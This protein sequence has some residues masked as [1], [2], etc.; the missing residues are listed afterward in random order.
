ML[1][2]LVDCGSISA[3]SVLGLLLAIT[4]VGVLEMK[5]QAQEGTAPPVVIQGTA[6]TTSGKPLA[7]TT[8]YLVDL[9]G[10]QTLS[11]YPA[12]FQ[13]K[14]IVVTDAQGRF[15]WTIPKEV[16]WNFPA[17]AS[18]DSSAPTC[19]ALPPGHGE[20]AAVFL[21]SNWRGA[22]ADIGR[23][24]L[25][26]D[27]TRRCETHWLE[28]GNHPRISVVAPDTGLVTLTV[29][30]T[31]GR[32]LANQRVQIVAPGTFTSY[33]GAVVYTVRTN[34]AGQ[35]SLARYT[36]LLRLLVSVPGTGFGST[37][38]F[39]VLSGKEAAPAL[40]P[41]APFAC[42][43][44]SVIPALVK[45]GAFVHLDDYG[46]ND[47]E[48]YQPQAAVDAR[49]HFMLAG[50]LPGQHRL[51]LA[52]GQ[53]AAA[54]EVTVH[55]GETVT[56]L[57]LTKLATPQGGLPSFLTNPV[58]GTKPTMCGRVVTTAGQPVEAA[59]V[60]A[61][62]SYNG[63]MR[64]Y[65]DVLTARTGADGSYAIANVPT[66]QGQTG[67]TLVAVKAGFPLGMG[68]ASVDVSKPLSLTATDLVLPEG[69][70][71]LTVRVLQN[72]KP[73]SGASVN[74]TPQVGSN[75][76]S[77]FRMNAGSGPAQ[78]R[79]TA[80]LNPSGT[81]DT[82][83][84][85]RF[86]DLAPG[87][88]DAAANLG[89]AASFFG[90]PPPG[91]SGTAR[92]IVV[93][94]G[95]P[96]RFTLGV[97]AAPG[98]VAFR[99]LAPGGQPPPEPSVALQLGQASEP[100]GG[101]GSGLTLDKEGNG[102]TSVWAP[103]LW[104][105]TTR[106]R[107]TPLATLPANTEP[108][109]QGSALVAVSPALAPAG[110]IQIRTV[111]HGPGRIRVRLEDRTGRR[112]AGTVT[113]GD[114]FDSAKYALSVGASGEAVFP[115]LPSGSYLL[116]AS[117]A[118]TIAPP[119]LG[120][121]GAAFPA[122]AALAGIAL[123]VPQ[124][125]VVTS[126]TETEVTFRPQ[127][128]GYIRGKL[129]VS[130]SPA[131]YAVYPGGYQEM[132]SAVHYEPKT[133]EFVVGPFPP[134]KNYLWVERLTPAN[135][136]LA[137][138]GTF[139]EDVPAG[140]VLT[141]TLTPQPPSVPLRDRP[142]TGR[143]FLPDGITPAWGARAAL[144]IPDSDQPVKMARTDALGQLNIFDYWNLSYWDGGGRPLTPMPGSPTEPVLVAWLPGSNGA[145]IIPS[146]GED[147][148]LVLPPPLSVSGRVTVGGQP[149]L[150]TPSSFRVKAAYQGRG[151]LNPL[152][153]VS[154]AVQ[155]DG[156]FTLSGLTLGTYQVQAARDDLWLSKTQV[157]TVTEGSQPP[158]T[159][160][161]APP[162]A[163]MLLHLATVSGNALPDQTVSLDRPTGP[164]TDLL[165]PVTA[166][167]D[168]HGDLRLDGLEAGPH[169]VDGTAA[170]TV[171][172]QPL[173]SP[174]TTAEF[175][176]ILNG[177]GTGKKSNR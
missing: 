62:C 140:R 77:F 103:G 39:Q 33:E 137:T 152:L 125:A 93:T 149:V 30:G 91:V 129:A 124:T 161:I 155:A 86:R 133:G 158:L 121:T 60:Y 22:N 174:R 25:W 46:V 151:K 55:A 64:G 81:T 17:N 50:V 120:H 3:R 68:S 171:P 28:T 56:G 29:H 83:G 26:E 170:F 169:T 71:A 173:M 135:E 102:H 145:V 115:D 162:G 128:L 54:A 65:Q 113:I 41:L 37:G 107:D 130:D 9:P 61:I 80:C 92:G 127:P 45:P 97:C 13:Q 82:S 84:E 109:Y 168:S 1:N 69:H 108:F 2:N 167:S 154:A 144:M 142:L 147:A 126:D 99:V 110:P 119:S 4:C 138:G 44:G 95:M 32:I 16:A 141:V 172:A 59:D 175:T 116:K 23:R 58:P 143:V 148:K 104:K 66:G 112:A 18:K 15:A 12:G 57:V 47:H 11:Q 153:S 134:G 98:D 150:G 88:W 10:S 163:V 35:F 49:G 131:H 85:V 38:T 27:A 157:L 132:P 21:A 146:T 63:G 52:G 6:T 78:G 14:I 122:D 111:H 19:Y 79:V 160:D 114:S 101:G 67:I 53:G 8:L 40:P 70:T 7:G 165:W 5:G 74:L 123:L 51:V 42:L 89:G 72:G 94:N 139:P 36:G 105:L 96:S 87:L 164:L 75:Q 166:A 73:L 136:G 24:S 176:V 90:S 117:F 118:K 106:F 177:P 34:T 43:S 76:F 31:D 100:N 20:Q 159:F 156:T 48:W